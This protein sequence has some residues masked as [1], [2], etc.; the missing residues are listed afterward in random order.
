MNQ[1][2]AYTLTK[3]LVV[4][5]LKPPHLIGNAVCF[6]LLRELSYKPWCVELEADLSGPSPCPLLTEES[7]GIVLFP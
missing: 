1:S 4:L 2:E 3:G 5:F 6:L 7:V